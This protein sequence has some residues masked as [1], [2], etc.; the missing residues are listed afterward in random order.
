MTITGRM[1]LVGIL[2][3]V[4]LTTHH[5]ALLSTAVHIMIYVYIVLPVHRWALSVCQS[6]MPIH[7]N[8]CLCLCLRLSVSV[9][10]SLS[11][12][13]SLYLCPSSH[14]S[15]INC[16]TRSPIDTVGRG[17]D[18]R[19]EREE[20]RMAKKTDRG[21]RAREDRSSGVRDDVMT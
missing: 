16:A 9:S 14:L 11:L 12:C 17:G 10:L 4:L 20:V 1:A 21:H 5:H 18:K 3:F 19:R 7:M 15:R 8:L 2:T 6:D 13:L